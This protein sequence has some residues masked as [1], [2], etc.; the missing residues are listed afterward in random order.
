MNIRSSCLFPR[1]GFGDIR[2]SGQTL[3][4]CT[5][6]LDVGVNNL[7][8]KYMDDSDPRLDLGNYLGVLVQGYQ[9]F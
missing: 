9:C 7:R 1:T 4:E 6:V 5:E 8:R 3:D 2:F